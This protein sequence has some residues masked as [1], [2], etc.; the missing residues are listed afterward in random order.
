MNKIFTLLISVLSFSQGFAQAQIQKSGGVHDSLKKNSRNYFEYIGQYQTPE[1]FMHN[2]EALA[3]RLKLLDQVPAGGEAKIM[4]FVYENGESTRLLA[5][6]MCLAAKRGVQVEFTPDS[7]HGSRPGV[8][9]VFDDNPHYQVN[10][11]VY[12]LL[13][14]C[15]V[16]VRVYNHIL[17]EQFQVLKSKPI[18]IPMLP[19]KNT[20]SAVGYLS[21]RIS[22]LWALENM[23]DD[24][25]ALLDEHFDLIRDDVKKDAVKL[26]ESFKSILRSTI[27]DYLRSE[28][29]AKAETIMETAE[30]IKELATKANQ[31]I[32]K[33]FSP[34]EIR[35]FLYSFVEKIQKHERLGQFYNGVRIF[36]RLNHRKLFFVSYDNQSCM[37]VGGRNLGDHYLTW[38]RHHDHPS[39]MDADVLVCSHHLTERDNDVFAEA[40]NSFLELWNNSDKQDPLNLKPE[41]FSI[42][43]NLNYEYNFVLFKDE[44]VDYWGN[45]LWIW[46]PT[47]KNINHT[48]HYVPIR[49]KQSERKYHQEL[50]EHDRLIPAPT[51][52]RNQQKVSGLPIQGAYGWDFHTTTWMRTKDQVR[53]QM[54]QAIDR[55]T[56]HI[57]IETAYGEMSTGFRQKLEKALQRGVEVEFVTNSYFI[58]DIGAKAIRLLSARWTRAMLEKYPKLFSARFAN[59]RFGHMIHFK[60]ASFKCQV[61]NLP[62]TSVQPYR[63][64]L[65][66]SHN[67]HGRSGYTDKEHAVTW[68]QNPNAKC[69]KKHNVQA[70]T[71]KDLKD[72]RNEYY[73]ELRQT[74]DAEH[75]PLKFYR[76]FYEEVDDAIKSGKLSQEREKISHWAVKLLYEHDVD[77][78]TGQYVIRKDQQGRA[79]LRAQDEFM[80]FME[81]LSE[82][83]FGD[84]IGTLL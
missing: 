34:A 48:E 5:A 73:S 29:S 53:D 4:T 30:K 27:M 28:E 78:V 57:Y 56:E 9:D 68:K 36:N 81:I 38:G 18:V 51:V 7:K 61:A 46:M 64:N 33:K 63:F 35:K 52:W 70:S 8:L 42:Q 44:N 77:A 84:L 62:G 1:I 37:F 66:G 10:E 24:L 14:N 20:S 65:I 82:S 59:V 49:W 40:R 15:G 72:F 13:V 16:K 25:N 69:A 19:H 47:K 26:K 32:L 83:G 74:V 22:N 58:D 71:D 17:D 80:K 76:T 41:V 6:H 45:P 79:K 31:D 54:Y 11:E 39:F 60:G 21:E 3:A 50:T 23:R 43:K 75:A 12:Q 67:F 55:E 2:E